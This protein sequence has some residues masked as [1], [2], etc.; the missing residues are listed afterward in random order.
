M[1]EKKTETKPVAKIVSQQIKQKKKEHERKG[2]RE[3]KKKTEKCSMY[4]FEPFLVYSFS[5]KSTTS[6]SR[7]WK[8]YVKGMV[9]GVT[10]EN[11]KP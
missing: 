1:D 2:K 9:T 3:S 8:M 11:G 5:A 10:G 6:S 7:S 4:I